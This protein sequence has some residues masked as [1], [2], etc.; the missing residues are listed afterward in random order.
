MAGAAAVK[1]SAE[2]IEAEIQRVELETKTLALERAKEENEQW[3]AKKAEKAKRN[4]VTQSDLAADRQKERNKTIGCRHRQGGFQ[5][6]FPKKGKGDPCISAHKMPFG[7]LR[8]QCNRCQLEVYEPNPSQ[9]NVKGYRDKHGRTWDEQKEVFD[10]LHEM[11]EEGGLHMSEGPQFTA[12][13]ADGIPFR[14][15]LV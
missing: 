7:E 13:T 10:K 1:M 14:P 4:A 8:L 5:D 15:A 2:E 11:F 6:S 3:K 12:L 9:R